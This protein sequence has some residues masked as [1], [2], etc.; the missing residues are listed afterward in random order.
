MMPECANC[1]H[2]KYNHKPIEGYDNCHICTGSLEC[3][4]EKYEEPYLTEFAQNIEK[5]KVKRWSIFD[6][7]EHILKTI[8]QIR[9]SGEKTFYKIYIEIWFGFKIRAASTSLTKKEWDRLPNQDTVSR[10]RRRVKQHNPDLESYDP[11]VIKGK[12]AIYETLM[13]MA[14][15]K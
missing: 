11:K 4:C 12:A 5:E 3:R 8:P 14:T 1:F 9:N 2:S 10:E 7:C 15:E 6:R 13:E